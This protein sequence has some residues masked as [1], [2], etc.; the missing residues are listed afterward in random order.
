MEDPSPR[1]FTKWAERVVEDE[2]M[3]VKFKNWQ[4]KD[5]RDSTHTACDEGCR[6]GI[7][8]SSVV[9]FKDDKDDCHQYISNGA[10]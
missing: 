1:S 7:Y 5:G 9:S 4:A 10:N 2:E 8:C 6:Q 3:A